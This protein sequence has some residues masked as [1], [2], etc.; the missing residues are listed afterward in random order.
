MGY[1]AN[2]ITL[3]VLMCASL[4]AH[5]LLQNTRQGDANAMLRL[6]KM[7][8]HGQGCER[9]LPMAQEWLRKAR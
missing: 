3:V 2:D 8:L 9:N 5:T 6:A 4:P 7:L 1:Y